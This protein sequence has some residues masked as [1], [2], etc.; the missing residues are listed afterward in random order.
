MLPYSVCQVGW[1]SVVSGGVGIPRGTGI[2]SG[3]LFQV[4]SVCCSILPFT[5]T[6]FKVH[7]ASR[8]AQ[9]VKNLP[10]RQETW[11]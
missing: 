8:V 3:T 2:D 5:H 9:T 4:L 10:A 11:V 6:L 7:L 1:S